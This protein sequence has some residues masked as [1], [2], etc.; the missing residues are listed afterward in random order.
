MWERLRAIV[1]RR[2]FA[3]WLAVAFAALTTRVHGELI[4]SGLVLQL[5]A[6]AGITLASGTNTVTQ[7]S[8]QVTGVPGAPVSLSPTSTTTRPNWL[9]AVEPSGNPAL[10]FIASD[11]D[12][13][14]TGSA[15]VFDSTSLTWMMALKPNSLSGVPTFLQSNLDTRNYAWGTFVETISGT[16]WFR[17]EVRSAAGTRYQSSINSSAAFGG[18]TLDWMILTSVFDKAASTMQLFITAADGARFSGNLVT[19][20][21]LADLPHTRLTIGTNTDGNNPSDMNLGGVLIY[22]TA[23]SPAQQ[24]ASEQYLFDIYAVPEPSATALAGIGCLAVALG[25]A[26]RGRE[27]SPKA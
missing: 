4:T 12:R 2:G 1:R 26:K 8:N 6:N 3:L 21:V 14:Q 27:R 10:Q 5:E 18:Q 25:L 13:V 15:A 24:L 23:L 22:N 16:T 20:A 7:W 17:S 11:R 9:A 19:G